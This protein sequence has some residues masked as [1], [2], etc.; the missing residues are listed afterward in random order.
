MKYGILFGLLFSAATVVNAAAPKVEFFLTKYDGRNCLARAK[1]ALQAS[2][3][4]MSNGTYQ[5]EDRVGITGNFKG[6]VGCS[7]E[8]PTSVV[9]VVSGPDYNT[10]KKL[11][12]K[13]KASF[14]AAK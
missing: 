1:I 5:G 12:R 4:K 2:G 11:A 13:M 6:A 8:V 7:T 3:F 9:F 14:I 10:A